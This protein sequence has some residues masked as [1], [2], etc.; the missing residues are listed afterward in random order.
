MIM[1]HD[2]TD[3]DGSVQ[4]FAVGQSAAV[5]LGATNGLGQHV[6]T[7]AQSAILKVSCKQLA[8]WGPGPM[9]NIVVRVCS[10]LAVYLISLLCE[11]CISCHSPKRHAR[12]ARQTPDCWRWLVYHSMGSRSVLGPSFPMS[13]PDDLELCLS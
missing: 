9:L 3:T 10:E 13:G 11:A 8:A 5:L 2:S 12:K 6:D 7:I 4:V 1:F